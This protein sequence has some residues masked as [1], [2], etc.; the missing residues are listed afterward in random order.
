MES[1]PAA[2][3]FRALVEHGAD[4]IWL[5]AEDGRILYANPASRAVV[6]YSPEDLAGTNALDYFLPTDREDARARLWDPGGAASTF[7]MRRKDGRKRVVWRSATSGQTAESADPASEKPTHSDAATTAEAINS[8]R[9]AFS[10][11]GPI[12]VA[13]NSRNRR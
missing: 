13:M 3:R 7:R 2:G 6:G 9:S 5:L 8:A 1:K 11:D 4:T 10:S 12:Q